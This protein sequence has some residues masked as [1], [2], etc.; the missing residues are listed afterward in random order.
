MIVSPR[1]KSGGQI[2]GNRSSAT[3]NDADIQAIIAA[4]RVDLVAL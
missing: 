2:I 4:S 3:T 1:F